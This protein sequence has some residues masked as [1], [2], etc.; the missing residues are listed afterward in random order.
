[1]NKFLTLLFLTL[2]I[3][4]AHAY[5]IKVYNN[6]SE[7]VTLGLTFTVPGASSYCTNGP[8]NSPT[9]IAYS[10]TIQPGTNYAFP[11]ATNDYEDTTFHCRLCPDSAFWP[12]R[13]R[14]TIC[15]AFCKR[16][17]STPNRRA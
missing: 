8:V 4:T 14:E 9:N 5:Q 6:S 3:S 7:A 13:R 11:T 17:T 1:M 16:G 2:C 15:T 10:A 12:G